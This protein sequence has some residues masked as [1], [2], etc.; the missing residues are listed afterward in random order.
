[1]ARV[2]GKTMNEKMHN[3]YLELQLKVNAVYDQ[4]LTMRNDPNTVPGLKQIL[5]KKEVIKKTKLL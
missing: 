3:A 1:M 5:E 4:D 2:V